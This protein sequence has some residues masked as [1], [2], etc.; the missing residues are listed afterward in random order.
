MTAGALAVLSKLRK[1]LAL[2]NLS[3]DDQVENHAH[4]GS[5]VPG[6]VHAQVEGDSDSFLRRLPSLAYSGAC[7]AFCHFLYH[8]EGTG[9]DVGGKLIDTIP[10]MVRFRLIMQLS[11][12]ER[13]GL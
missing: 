7:P 11:M 13:D 6:C 9:R 5:K 4:F 8:S 1:P 10:R 3:V 2:I 12:F